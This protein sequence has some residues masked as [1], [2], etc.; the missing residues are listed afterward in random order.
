MTLTPLSPGAL[1]LSQYGDAPL[2]RNPVARRTD[3]TGVIMKFVK[4]A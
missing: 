2:V 3:R 1:A 4:L